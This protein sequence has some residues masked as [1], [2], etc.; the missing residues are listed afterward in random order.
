MHAVLA[1]RVSQNGVLGEQPSGAQKDR[2]L[3]VLKRDCRENGGFVTPS[4]LAE[5]FEF[6]VLTPLMS[7]QNVLNLLCHISSGVGQVAQSV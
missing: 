4:S 1:R 3:R 2:S 5:I 7:A 6:V